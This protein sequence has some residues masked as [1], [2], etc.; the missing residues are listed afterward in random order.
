MNCLEN[1]NVSNKQLK[2]MMNV[3][4]SAN[5]S[6]LQDCLNVLKNN[7]RNYFQYLL[8]VQSSEDARKEKEEKKKFLIRKV[9]IK[10]F[11]FC[12]FTFLINQFE[13]AINTQRDDIPETK[14][15]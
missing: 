3:L 4:T 12:F 6:L 14:K 7:M 9:I 10:I 11:G 2:N 15:C 8:I 1:M 5:C 13:I